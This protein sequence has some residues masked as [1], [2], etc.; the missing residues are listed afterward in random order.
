MRE[1]YRATRGCVTLLAV[2]SALVSLGAAGRDA[3]ILTAV[4]QGDPA[5]VRVLIDR[6]VDVNAA[7][8]DGTTALHWAAHRDSLEM[9]DLLI[10]AG[11]TAKT[12]NRYGVTPLS[13]AATNGNAAIIRRLLAAGADPNATLPGGETVLMSA[14]RTGNVDALRTLLE[15]GANVNARESTR[16][17]TALMWAAAQG[18]ARAVTLLVEAGAAVDARSHGPTQAAAKGERSTSTYQSASEVD[19]DRVARGAAPDE[20]R[21]NSAIARD[22]RRPGRIDAY[23]PLLFAV[24]AGHGE[25]VRALLDAG[26]NVNDAAPDGTSALVIAAINAHWELGAFL[27]DRGA[28]PDAAAQG[29]TPLH[30]VAR[31][32]TLNIGQ[33][34]YPVPT[35]RLT[36]LDL[37]RR[38]I[39]R[40]ANVNA[41]MTKEIVDGY[42]NR[43]NRVGATPLLLAAK[44]ADVE[45]IRLLA[46]NGA[47][48]RLPNVQNTTPL[49]AAAGVDML[50]VNEDSG[51]NEDALEAVKVLLDLGSDVNVANARGETALHGAANR[52]SNPIVQLLADKGAR[53]DAK[54]KR[55]FTPLQ[56]A[57]AEGD[58]T[59]FQRRPETVELFRELMIARGIPVDESSFVSPVVRTP[60]R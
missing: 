58:T 42:R 22:Y 60:P 33:F 31:T 8:V 7:D 30:Q 51:T 25:A 34:P 23:T 52:G 17:Q 21:L 35:G 44:G 2:L 57:N 43:F 29:W 1:A 14:A 10:G 38:L 12:A 6:K 41:R 3:S 59:T 36:G 53:L 13:L 9:V 39:A 40:G 27:L 24:R 5:A 32:R 16:G 15:V 46:A 47:D 54:N 20:P 55:G 50:Y 49:L 48:P 26:A 45:M 18:N 37:A 28:D 56:I 4:R 19:P 11:A